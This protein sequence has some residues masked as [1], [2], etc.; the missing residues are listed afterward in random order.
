MGWV[1][2]SYG[3]YDEMYVRQQSQYW[4]DGSPHGTDDSAHDDDND[5]QQVVRRSS[6]HMLHAL[7]VHLFVRPALP[8][9]VDGR[10]RKWRI[11]SLA[12]QHD[13]W[14]QRSLQLS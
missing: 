5:S 1:E 4:E 12:A 8:A 6:P 7:V 11:G 10:G 13:A 3:G 2:D 9:V 14:L